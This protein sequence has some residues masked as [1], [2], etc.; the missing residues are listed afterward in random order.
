M[1]P[2][3]AG[4]G[5]YSGQ[6]PAQPPASPPP[7]K[8]AL[9]R[10][11]RLFLAVVSVLMMVGGGLQFFRSTRGGVSINSRCDAVPPDRIRCE[12]QSQ[13]GSGEVCQDVVLVC[14]DGEHVAHVCSGKVPKGE[15]V[16]RVLTL[17][18]FQPKVDP[19]GQCTQITL[20][21]GEL[22]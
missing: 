2:S 10:R 19:T 16:A 15:K 3:L 1:D 6:P 5:G 13:K 11:Q 7:A 20:R 17:A 14:A 12:Y 9:P 8:P 18:E 21:N 22:K 4:S